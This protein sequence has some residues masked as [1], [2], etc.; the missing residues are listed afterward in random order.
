MAPGLY[1]YSP[2]HRLGGS[3][4]SQRERLNPDTDPHSRH[5]QGLTNHDASV[6]GSLRSRADG[7]CPRRSDRDT[8]S[9]GTLRV[10]FRPGVAPRHA[11]HRGLIAVGLAMAL[12]GVR[13]KAFDRSHSRRVV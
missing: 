12:A 7:A 6:E 11:G 9:R 8:W 1:P 5:F 13:V 10:G 3:G 2:A 4:L